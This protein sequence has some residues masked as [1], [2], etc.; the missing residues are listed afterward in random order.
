MAI[1]VTGVSVILVRKAAAISLDL[2]R[3]SVTYLARHRAEYWKGR[4][5]GYIRALHSLASIMSDY[6]TYP[7]EERRGHFDKMLSAIIDSEVNMVAVF[8]VWKP[9]AIDGMDERYIGRT[10]SGPTGYYA[11][12]YLKETGKLT[13]RTC[14]D[15]DNTMAYITGPNARKDRVDHPSPLVING[16][17]TFIIRMA[18]PIVNPATNEV[19][20]CVGCYMS[21]DSLQTIVESVIST[22][23]EIAAVSIYSG[24]GFILG[25]YMPERV[26]KMLIDE[27]IQYGSRKDEINE[28]VLAGQEFSLKSWSPQLNTNIEMVFVPVTIGNSNTTWTIMIGVSEAYM[29]KEV[30]AITRFTVILALLAIVTAAVIIYFVFSS[31]TKPIIRVT[32]TLKDISEGEGDLTRLLPETGNDEIT[33]M[34]RYFNRTLAK[35]KYLIIA[36]KQQAAVLSDT[37]NEL[38]GNM[39]ET[40][41]AINEITA[42]IQ[43]IKSRVMN[44]SASVT[45]T[46]ATMEQV[47]TNL[48]KLD[49]YIGNQSDEVSSAAGAVDGLIASIKSVTAT[50][51]NNTGN[52]HELKKISEAGHAGI[53]DMASDIRKIS[54]ESEDLVTINSVM[55][56]I[57]SQTNFLSMNAA[58]E[59]AHAGEAGRGFAVVADEIRKLAESSGEQSAMVGAVLQNIKKS[60]D[61]M[62]QSSEDVI[63]RFEAIDTSV[64]TVALEEE[65]ILGAMEKQNADSRML[66][67]NAGNVSNITLQVKS[68]SKEMLEGSKEVIQESHNL[69]KATHEITNGM[70][71]I[72]AGANEINDAVNHVNEISSKN[73]E[74]INA[75]IKE[76]SRFKVA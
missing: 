48:N 3:Q 23:D 7:A 62:T 25:S 64:K 40:A 38:S 41:S 37:S 26:G 14:I 53:Q 11:M 54:L 16:K 42:S 59:A 4:E 46:N 22:H 28:I 69:E 74:G 29:L 68:R 76:V 32:H 13:G 43:S 67:Q 44:Q 63:T 75:L 12:S 52:V 70:N 71:E 21:I 20:G 5:E 50:L 60:I 19:V 45:E 15:I 1:V 31:I 8:S 36:I 66:M 10:G 30:N 24:N 27:E 65:N 9:N 2:S 35:I 72:A 55:K 73:R 39:T 49:G 18:V 58:I 56:N 57:A 34:S 6:E 17:D 61:K 51:V 33:D 47:V